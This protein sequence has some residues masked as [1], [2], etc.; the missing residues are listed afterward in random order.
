M[1]RRVHVTLNPDA[2][3]QM[4]GIRRWLRKWRP[5]LTF[6]DELDGDSRGTHTYR[7]EG[8]EEAITDL[9]VGAIVLSDAPDDVSRN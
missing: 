5:A 9:P 2:V 7:L 8:P 3:D 6:V 1:N 4:A